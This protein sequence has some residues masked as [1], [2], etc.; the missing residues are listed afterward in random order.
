V[1]RDE[2]E[3]AYNHGFKH[4]MAMAGLGIVIGAGL[5][6][7]LSACESAPAEH[8]ELERGHSAVFENGS[9][10]SCEAPP[11]EARGCPPEGTTCDWSD[12]EACKECRS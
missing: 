12:P 10:A 11:R 1:I 6:F 5:A 9:T 2:Y 4:G 3:E 8:V 7:F